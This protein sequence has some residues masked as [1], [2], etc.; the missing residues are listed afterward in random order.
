MPIGNDPFIALQDAAQVFTAVAAILIVCFVV[1]YRR[2]AQKR[3]RYASFGN[4]GVALQELQKIARP[5]I[6][7]QIEEQQKMDVEDDE[8]GGPDDPDRYYRRLR[9]K[10]DKLNRDQFNHEDEKSKTD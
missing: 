3:G 5:S 7:Y 4:I 8:E 10:I 6:E 2:R 1:I 9:E